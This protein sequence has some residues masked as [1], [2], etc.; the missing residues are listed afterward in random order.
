MYIQ[1]SRSTSLILSS[2]LRGISPTHRLDLTADAKFVSND[3]QLAELEKVAQYLQKWP[4][5][6]HFGGF[7][8][9]WLP[10]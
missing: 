2:G 3:E 6:S 5:C 7:K 8:I 10:S 9:S 4:S 1:L